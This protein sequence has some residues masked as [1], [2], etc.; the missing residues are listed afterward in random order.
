MNIQDL[1]AEAESAYFNADTAKAH[2]L[3]NQILAQDSQHA[4]SYFLKAQIAFG[5]N[6]PE[7]MFENY[8]KAI[9]ANPHSKEYRLTLAQAKLAEAHSPALDKQRVQ[10][11]I[12]DCNYII[13]EMEADIF[14]EDWNSGAYE[15][16]GQA[17]ALSDRWEEAVF[18]FDMARIFSP[19]YNATMVPAMAGIQAEKLNNPEA[20]LALWNE[21]IE[22]SENP[23]NEI[24]G[25]SDNSR[26]CAYYGRGEL[27]IKHLNQ[28]NDGLADLKKAVEYDSSFQ[29]ACEEYSR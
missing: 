4:A 3:L 8:K 26:A 12:D 28:K 11:V 19:R 29:D 21:Y 2:K 25:E 5:E 23:N 14:P 20:A 17:E 15:L 9:E 1:F 10:E 16:R 18:S 7:A 13:S 27:K 6:S 22:F 24:F